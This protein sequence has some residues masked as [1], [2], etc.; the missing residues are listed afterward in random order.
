MKKILEF[1]IALIISTIIYPLGFL[2]NLFTIHKFKKFVVYYYVL[3][4][5]VLKVIL[6]F[7]RQ[8]AIF[9]DI[10]ANVIAGRLFYTI[11][12]NKS[13]KLSET[14]FGKSQWT[15]SASI[16]HVETS[17]INKLNSKGQWFSKLLSKVL[18]EKNHCLNAYY[19][20]IYKESYKKI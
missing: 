13:L 20:K 14:Y 5:Q 8:I 16:G 17:K 18:V 19:F 7:F 6:E 10:L 4:I 15:I 12:V 1:I 9:L 2:F 11:L 3:T